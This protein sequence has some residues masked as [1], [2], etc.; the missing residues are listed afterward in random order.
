MGF[1]KRNPPTDPTDAM[2]KGLIA[3]AGGSP[4]AEDRGAL[5][6][7]PQMR[8]VSRERPQRPGR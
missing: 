3:E 6:P 1:L 2:A 8:H 7:R 5:R 4:R